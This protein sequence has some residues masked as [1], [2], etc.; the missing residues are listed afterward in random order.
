MG[1]DDALDIWAPQVRQYKPEDYTDT[2]EV[3]WY[4]CLYKVPY[5]T[6]TINRPA[7]EVRTQFWACAKYR[8][9]GFLYWSSIYW[10]TSDDYSRSASRKKEDFF[11]H[12]EWPV[13]FDG[14]DFPGD[15]LFFYPDVRGGHP[16][17]PRPQYPRRR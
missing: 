2:D 9:S 1:L 15:A 16:Q 5:P 17:H 12:P 14:T 7:L 8:V 10:G 13:P 6:F 11:V 4:Q 3:W